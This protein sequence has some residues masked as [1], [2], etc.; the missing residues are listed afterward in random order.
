[1]LLP[2]PPGREIFVSTNK[3]TNRYLSI[4]HFFSDELLQAN[5]LKGDP[6]IA[7][8]IVF[9]IDPSSRAKVSFAEN[10]K[11]FD[12]SEFKKFFTNF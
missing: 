1:M 5:G 8:S 2:I 7:D 12:V 9:E 3:L 11:N 6:V 4:E 10:A